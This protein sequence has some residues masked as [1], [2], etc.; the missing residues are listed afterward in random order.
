MSVSFYGCSLS[1][2]NYDLGPTISNYYALHFFFGYKNGGRVDYHSGGWSRLRSNPLPIGCFSPAEDRTRDLPRRKYLCTH[3][4]GKQAW[5]T[6]PP[7]QTPWVVS[8][9]FSF[10]FLRLCF[11]FFNL[12]GSVPDC[13]HVERWVLCL[14]TNVLLP[15]VPL[16]DNNHTLPYLTL[17]F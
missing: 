8:S 16:V 14:C 3:S 11:W 9:I 2:C 13:R 10:F 5:P 7:D 6:L 17:F 12:S 4:S 1:A 15:R